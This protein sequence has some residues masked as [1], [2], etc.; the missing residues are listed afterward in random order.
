M[1]RLDVYNGYMGGVKF[2]VVVVSTCHYVDI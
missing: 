2:L 1:K